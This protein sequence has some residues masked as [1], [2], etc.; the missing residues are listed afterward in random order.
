M[1]LLL[2]LYIF[3]VF[4]EN[5]WK[6]SSSELSSFQKTYNLKASIVS[7][8]VSKWFLEKD[9]ITKKLS[10]ETK[11]L[12]RDLDKAHTSSAELEQSIAE[13]NDPLKKCQDEKSIAE[14][15]VQDST[16]DLEKL[17]KTHE[18]DLN[19]IENLRKDSDKNAK[20]IDELHASNAELSTKNSDLAKALSGKEPNIQDL[21]RLYLS[22]RN[23]QNK[24]LRKLR[25]VETLV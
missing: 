18:D 25:K 20:T 12:R 22:E 17:K 19:L 16:K 15:A 11:K 9:E 4:E 10:G 13:L 14:A 2:R 21:E 5:A 1:I 24:M 7:K 23:L 8:V 3:A 6:F